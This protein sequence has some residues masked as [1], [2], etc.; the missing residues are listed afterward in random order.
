MTI[1][2]RLLDR[3]KRRARDRG[4]TLGVIVEESLQR[5]LALP[6]PVDVEAPPLAVFDGGSGLAPGIDPSSNASLHAASGADE[7]DSGVFE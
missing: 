1:D 3:A 7:H 4:T 6:N 5:F 2:D